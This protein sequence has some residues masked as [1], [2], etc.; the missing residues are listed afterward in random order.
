[1]KDNGLLAN[2]NNRGCRLDTNPKFVKPYW[3]FAGEARLAPRYTV[4]MYSSNV[5]QQYKQQIK[6]TQSAHFNFVQLGPSPFCQP[7]NVHAKL[8][9]GLKPLRVA[10]RNAKPTISNPKA[11]IFETNSKLKI[12]DGK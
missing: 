1:M 4:Q 3:L 5:Q 9:S 12:E 2:G 7:N 10:D 8:M 11:Q 6:C